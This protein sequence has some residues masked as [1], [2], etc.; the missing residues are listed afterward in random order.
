MKKARS[1]WDPFPVRQSSKGGQIKDISVLSDL[2]ASIFMVVARAQ[3]EDLS[4]TPTSAAH[5]WAAETANSAENLQE[6]LGCE[7]CPSGFQMCLCKFGRRFLAMK[8]KPL[9][10]I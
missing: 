9:T 5:G 4:H 8:L 3:V 7:G 2:N 6:Q 1:V 10:K